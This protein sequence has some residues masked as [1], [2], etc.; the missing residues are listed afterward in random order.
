MLFSEDPNYATPLQLHPTGYHLSVI[1][2]WT[3]TCLADND[4]FF[5]KEKILQTTQGKPKCCRKFVFTFMTFPS[6]I[7][8]SFCVLG[9]V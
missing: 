9:I 8:V 4:T 7:L 1:T 6:L 2:C 5:A 3:N